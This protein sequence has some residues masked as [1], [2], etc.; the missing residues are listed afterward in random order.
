[1]ASK[2]FKSVTSITKYMSEAEET[3]KNEAE[4]FGNETDLLEKV[5][6]KLAALN[7]ITMKTN[8]MDAETLAQLGENDRA[9]LQGFHADQLPTIAVVK[10]EREDGDSEVDSDADSEGAADTLVF[11][12]ERHLED[13]GIAWANLDSWDFN[14]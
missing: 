6:D 11:T 14:C 7:A 1:M 10:R 12:L 13:A 3:K 2:I 9:V 5:I 8:P 4:M